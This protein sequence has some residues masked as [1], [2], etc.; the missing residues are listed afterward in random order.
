MSHHKLISFGN[1]VRFL[2][3]S[4]ATMTMMIMIAPLKTTAGSIYPAYHNREILM[5]ASLA[6]SKKDIPNG[7]FPIAIC[8]LIAPERTETS[9]T[10]LSSFTQRTDKTLIVL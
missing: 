4:G 6:Y 2:D 7:E 5:N 10:R 3:R 1:N 8:L 9:T